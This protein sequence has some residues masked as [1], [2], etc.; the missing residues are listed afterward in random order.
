MIGS[1]RCIVINVHLKYLT[2][3]VNNIKQMNDGS[4]CNVLCR[5]YQNVKPTIV[6]NTAVSANTTVSVIAKL[7][8]SF[9]PLPM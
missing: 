5:A 6:H 1:V 8:S 9:I 2:L 3:A 7:M 4:R